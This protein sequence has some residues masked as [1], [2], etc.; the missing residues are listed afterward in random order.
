M[1]IL[2]QAGARLVV[3]PF[4]AVR[5][6]GK[7]IAAI[8]RQVV[9]EIAIRRRLIRRLRRAAIAWRPLSIARA[10]GTATTTTATLSFARLARSLFLAGFTRFGSLSFL[11]RFRRLVAKLHID[12]LVARILFVARLRGGLL[13]RR[14]IATVA[15][16]T[17]S[18]ATST[19]GTALFIGL[20]TRFR[21][22]R[23]HRNVFHQLRI[24]RF[25]V[26]LD[27]LVR[28]GS[29]RGRGLA[30]SRLLDHRRRSLVRRIEDRIAPRRS[31][32]GRRFG[33]FAFGAGRL[34]FDGL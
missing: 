15:P 12:L 5:D 22:S 26:E 29:A 8:I 1:A 4:V 31:R 3:V 7:L 2:I 34:R 9:V 19:A 11:H 28:D 33:H 27:R 24:D 10:S 25:F 23:R 32:L 18:A 17:A 6:A 16:A 14:S 13:A 21:R 20:A 30:R